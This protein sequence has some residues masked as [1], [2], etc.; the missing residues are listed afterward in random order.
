MEAVVTMSLDEFKNL[1]IENTSLKNKL[2]S[3]KTKV[4]NKA[5]EE[6]RDS[7]IDNIKTSDEALQYLKYSDD[8]IL[9]KFASS[10]SYTWRSIS[11][12]AYNIMS[13]NEIKVLVVSEIKKRIDEK[14]ISLKDEEAG[15]GGEE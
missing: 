15:K 9:E 13:V 5:F 4:I 12:D 10:Y 1:I 2:F 8:K 3:L 6:I 11:D 14:C 7:Y